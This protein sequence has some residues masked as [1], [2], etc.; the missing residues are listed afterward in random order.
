MPHLGR[1][2]E[3]LKLAEN[4][5]CNVFIES[6]TYDGASF[7]IASESGL[8]ERCYS[9]EI[10]Q[11]LYQGLM[12]RYPEKPD[13]KVFLGRSHEIFVEQIFPLCQLSD[14]IFFWLDGHYSKGK[15]GGAEYPCPLLDELRAIKEYCPTTS[16]VIAIDDTD[17]FDR[18][19]LN[20]PGLNWPTETQVN[21]AAYQIN[22]S[23]FRLDLTRG[24]HKLERGI[25]V[26]SYK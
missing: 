23:F 10:K 14:R 25:L 13:R 19:D 8:F 4:K 12:T 24:R 7:K 2:P 6:G 22:P 20:V 26:F 1:V 21:T 9:V 15:T 5:N 11:R 17:D 16:V 3:I 18:K